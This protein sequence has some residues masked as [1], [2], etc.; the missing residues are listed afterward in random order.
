MCTLS[1]LI[2][3]W[4]RVLPQKLTVTQLVKKS[5]ACDGSRMFFTAFKNACHPSLSSARSI[6][7]IPHSISLRSILILPSHLQLDLKSDLLPSDLPTKN[8]YAPLVSPIRAACPDHFIL[9][10][11]ITRITFGQ[12]YRSLSPSLCSFLHSPVTSSLSTPSTPLNTLFSNTLSLLNFT[13]QLM[14]FYI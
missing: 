14:H 9:L 13:H 11:M 7:L 1:L 6:Q 5:P 12:Q 4:S 2:P 8:L 3:P 10:P